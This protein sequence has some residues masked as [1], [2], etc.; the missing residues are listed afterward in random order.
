[1]L[2]CCNRSVK[3]KLEINI[4]TLL[5]ERITAMSRTICLAVLVAILSVAPVCAQDWANSLFKVKK[6]NFGVVAR[7]AKTKYVF[8]MENCFATDVH[9]AS[10][11]TSCGCTTPS[12]IK[13]DLTTYECGGILAVF[14]TDSFLGH[15]GATITVTFDRPRYA[16]VQLRVDGEIR[17]EVTAEP[18]GLEFGNINVGSQTQR[19]LT[20]TYNGG[21]SGWRIE[22]IRSDNP[23]LKCR[24]EPLKSSYGRRAYR[25]TA[26]LAA[27]TPAG[28]YN[29][30]VVLVTNDPSAKEIPIYVSARVK[31]PV[32]V[33]P[34]SLF[35]G[36]VGTEQQV[37]KK[38]VVIGREPFR[39][40]SVD[41]DD[42][43]KFTVGDK[44]KKV[45]IVPLTFT[46]G[47][48]SGKLVRT[49]RVRTDLGEG[50]TIE[51]TASAAI[52]S[53]GS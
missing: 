43:F 36:V 6:H 12:I 15:R 52:V 9:V 1:M 50:M 37:T 3:L 27:D 30:P 24:A 34:A 38:L 18:G 5:F 17:G 45:H 41:C 33:S 28:L 46:A 40:L 22:K 2:I 32:T 31:P 16:E 21:R 48:K 20:I 7:N 23:H 51:C 10:V 35:L 29:E 53:K 44:A 42:C 19:Q 14:N 26:T 47:A 11:R 49:I 39:I 4:R 25:I 13:S 8:E